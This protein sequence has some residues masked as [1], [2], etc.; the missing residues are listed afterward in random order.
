M[1]YAIRMTDVGTTKKSS[2][3]TLFTVVNFIGILAM[4]IFVLPDQVVFN[5]NAKFEI[6]G[7]SHKDFP[8]LPE[9]DATY[10]ISLNQ[11]VLKNMNC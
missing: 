2:L 6:L 8:A 3:L 7:I 4:V 9:I 11:G 1:G 5:I 10:S